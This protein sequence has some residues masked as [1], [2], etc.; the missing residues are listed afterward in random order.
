MVHRFIDS[1]FW[2]D[3]IL[4]YA[5]SYRF[6]SHKVYS[7]KK[8]TIDKGLLRK[9][10]ENCFGDMELLIFACAISPPEF[11]R[12]LASPRGASWA[13]RIL[14]KNW[15]SIMKVGEK[16][17]SKAE[18]RAEQLIRSQEETRTERRK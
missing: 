4:A 7:K 14:G 1:G 5:I 6:I 13:A 10:W 17:R 16:P 11:L 3:E 8:G 2:L 12:F 9:G 15:D 18:I